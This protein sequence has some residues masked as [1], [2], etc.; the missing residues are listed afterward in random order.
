[1]NPIHF[2][3]LGYLEEYLIIGII[4]GIIIGLY[5]FFRIRYSL[6]DS[7]L[8]KNK[9]MIV[10]GLIAIV[11]F[12]F[13]LNIWSNAAILA[14]YLFIASLLADI[15]RLIWKYVL[16]DKPLKF[17]PKL[18]KKGI[19]A[20]IIFAIIIIHGVYGMN[21]IDLTEYNLTSDKIDNEYSILFVS[22][23]HYD[24]VQDTKLVKESISKMNDLKPD[25][26][27][28][29]GDICDD[30]TPKESMKEIFKEF[31]TINSTYGTYYVYGNHD[32]QPYETD[33]ENGN[34]TYS[35][36]ELADAIKSSGIRIMEDEKTTF[37]DDIVLVGRADAEWSGE[38]NRLNI[39]QL[40]DEEDLSKFIV[41]ADHQPIEAE[42]ST[43]QGADLQISGHTHGG[44]VFP[45]EQFQ[46]LMGM[47]PYGEYD[48]GDGKLIVSSG[49]TGWGW[50]MRNQEKCEYVLIHIN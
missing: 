20:L 26:V 11:A 38:A 6:N 41:V 48:V 12:L 29:G 7:S 4:F 45:Y 1:M 21:H 24:T 22:D 25:I 30:R 18:H 44:Q 34:R 28:L 2:F 46:K 14:L 8:S 35:D 16:K 43:N 23:V 17:I 37:N 27:I 32:R 39:S 9:R 19:L 13:C 49:L 47:Y 40:I 50:P 31:G 42:E 15:I 10:A 3:T 36:E 33:Y 5:A